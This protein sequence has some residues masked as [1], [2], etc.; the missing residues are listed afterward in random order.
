MPAFARATGKMLG[1]LPAARRCAA[2]D[3]FFDYRLG[4]RADITFINYFG[5]EDRRRHFATPYFSRAA[6]PR[7]FWGWPRWA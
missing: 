7:R 5:A 3:F 2:G 6:L 1:A 4:A